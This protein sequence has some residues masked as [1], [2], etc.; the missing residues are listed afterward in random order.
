MSLVNMEYCQRAEFT[1][2]EE[3]IAAVVE[4]AG[5]EQGLVI[6]PDNFVRNLES[7]RTSPERESVQTAKFLQFLS[8]F[9]LVIKARTGEKFRIRLFAACRLLSNRGV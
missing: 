2:S 5:G 1:P 3:E 8:Q 6:P 9:E 7:S 4:Q